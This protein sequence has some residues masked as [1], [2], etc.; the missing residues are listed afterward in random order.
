[1]RT[2]KSVLLTVDRSSLADEVAKGEAG[3]F[4]ILQRVWRS[5]AA[6]DHSPVAATEF[7]PG[8]FLSIS[9]GESTGSH[10]GLNIRIFSQVG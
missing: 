9:G 7:R 8:R 3:L 5:L 10:F 6:E 2:A 4:L 1:M